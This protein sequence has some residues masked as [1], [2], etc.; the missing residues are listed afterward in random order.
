[1]STFIKSLGTSFANYFTLIAHA[2]TRKELL[3]Y[4]DRF[5][6]DTGFSRD[7]LEQGVSAWP[8]RVSDGAT[9]LPAMQSIDHDVRHAVSELKAYSDAE[10]AD[11]ALSRAGIEQAV[12]S[13]RPGLD[14]DTDRKAA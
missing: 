6:A 5:L 12:R 7:L 13:G 3:T 4:S 8:W 14:E 2:R 11:L 10:L 1:M 9:E